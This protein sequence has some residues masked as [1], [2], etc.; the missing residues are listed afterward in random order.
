MRFNFIIDVLMDVTVID[1]SYLEIDLLP[2]YRLSDL[3]YAGEN[4]LLGEKADET[5]SLPSTST[6][7]LR[8]FGMRFVPVK[9]KMVQ[10]EWSAP[11]PS[12]RIGSEVV[13]RNDDDFTYLASCISHT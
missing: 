2:S 11:T 1:F 8:V 7:N 6:R 3:E 4:F 5:Q 12:L 10:Q 13:E 9:C